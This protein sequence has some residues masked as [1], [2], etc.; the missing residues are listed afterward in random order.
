MICTLH[1][2]IAGLHQAFGPEQG[3]CFFSSLGLGFRCWRCGMF[4]L[5]LWSSED[6]CSLNE[7]ILDWRL[8]ISYVSWVLANI[9]IESSS[10]CF[11]CFSSVGLGFRCRHC[12][13]FQLSLQSSQ[14]CCCLNER[15]LD[16]CLLISYV[17]WVLANIMIESSFHCFCK[18]NWKLTMQILYDA[19]RRFWADFH[20]YLH[21]L[22]GA[23][24]V[25]GLSWWLY[26]YYSWWR[27]WWCDTSWAT[28]R[29]FKV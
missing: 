3:V 16:W 21:S 24:A 10:H 20:T 9:M 19:L 13:M 27:R 17:P 12:G 1:L 7:R 15:T 25:S 18:C 26:Q 8:L 4:Q 6:C 2:L 28:V 5:S 11:C 14:D 23:D 29:R 22:S